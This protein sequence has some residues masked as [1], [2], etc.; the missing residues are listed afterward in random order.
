MHSQILHLF[1]LL[2]YLRN[3]FSTR[4][5]Q[6]VSSRQILVHASQSFAPCL[7]FLHNCSAKHVQFR[8]FPN[9]SE[10]CLSLKGGNPPCTP[11]PAF[12]FSL[13]QIVWEKC[14]FA[15]IRQFD[16]SAIA[17]HGLFQNISRTIFVHYCCY[18]Y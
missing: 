11:L 12:I 8:R 15:H 2:N 14:K 4:L 16:Y 9:T 7:A 17:Y 1:S 5:C 10:R 13:L 18:C 3:S 6:S